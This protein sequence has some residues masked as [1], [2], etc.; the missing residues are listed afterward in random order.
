VSNVTVNSNPILLSVTNERIALS[1]ASSELALSVSG[2]NISFSVVSNPVA[3]T[4]ESSEIA[5]SVASN[6]VVIEFNTGNVTITNNYG[7]DT[8]AI[9]AAENLGGHRIITVEGYYASKDTASDKFK[10][11]G[12][13]TGAV[14]SGSEATVQV[15]GFIT[16]SGWNFTVGNPI[17][18]STNGH[19]T[20]TAPT[21]GFCQIV[22]KPKTATTIFIEIN[23]PF[24]LA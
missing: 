22:A 3:I 9:T 13:T 23:E 1:V 4:V 21:T 16:E 15:S 11:L 5:L 18:L 20:Q 7:A 10:V 12:M 8:V 17:F 14:S 6:P 24:I 19:I 2:T